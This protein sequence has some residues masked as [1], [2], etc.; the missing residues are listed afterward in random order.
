MGN[1]ALAESDI[2]K[3]HKEKI[4]QK[5]A[6]V[7]ELS[8]MLRVSENKARQLTHSKGFPVIVMGRDRLTVLSKLDKW[9]EDN[10]GELF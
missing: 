5:T 10:I 7:K 6:T 1:L 8:I 2:I 9:L 3:D 4:K